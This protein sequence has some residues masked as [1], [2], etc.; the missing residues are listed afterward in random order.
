[1]LQDLGLKL[2]EKKFLFVRLDKKRI[3]SI[4]RSILKNISYSKTS[5]ETTHYLVEGI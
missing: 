2:K 5:N 4:Q 3:I 1:M